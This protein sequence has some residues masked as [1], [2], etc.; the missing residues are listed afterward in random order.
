MHP[1]MRLDI[2]A[3]DLA[4]AVRACSSGLD[5]G[6]AAR[7]VEERWHGGDALACLSVRSG[8]DLLLG[9]LALPAGSEVLMSAVTIPDMPRLVRHHGLVP[10]PVDLDLESLAPALEALERAR[11]PRSRLVVVAHLFGGRVEL[12]PFV[13]FARRHG[14]V[15]V[16]DCAQAFRHPRETGH[17]GADVSMF[18]FGTIKTLTALGGALLRVRDRALLAAMRTREAS[19]PT[20]PTRRYLQKVLKIGGLVA[21]TDPRAYGLLARA[22]GWVGKDLDDVVGPAVKGFPL[23]DATGPG[24]EGVKGR[25]LAGR[26]RH[27]A[28]AAMLSLLDRRLERFAPA[29]VEGRA[30]T[31]EAV[32]AAL[33]PGAFL[34]GR[35]ALDR[36]H[37]L[38]PVDV[39]HPTATVRALRA[40]GFDASS[41]TSSLHAVAAPPGRPEVEP[42][43]AARMLRDLVFLPV[44]AALDE[45]ALRRLLS[46]LALTTGPAEPPT[47][48]AAA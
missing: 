29:T 21:A 1:R 45:H 25:A 16:E 33:P 3:R 19:W 31:G 14:L 18:S 32:L 17:P 36:T 39:P 13:A 30:T 10:V 15:L 40:A 5:R 26:V 28:P 35:R 34:P 6:R 12:A 42:R 46:A 37:W 4:Y 2:T 23:P 7:T 41:S 27:R 44:N 20:V 43:E 11:T 22:C 8:F 47:V 9:E 24:A 48:A 38:F